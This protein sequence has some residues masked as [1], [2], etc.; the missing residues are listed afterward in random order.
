[1]RP[2]LRT[3]ERINNRPVQIRDPLSR[4]K[5]F[6]TPKR[7][8]RTFRI[9]RK[10]IAMWC[11]KLRR[12]ILRAHKRAKATSEAARIKRTNQ[13]ANN[14]RDSRF[15]D[16]AKATK[17]LF[18]LSRPSTAMRTTTLRTTSMM[19]TMSLVEVLTQTMIMSQQSRR[20]SQLTRMSHRSNA[21]RKS[22]MFR[23]HQMAFS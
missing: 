22:T 20:T 10:L 14:T 11:N 1:M 9:M 21:D 7:G 4:E 17:L 12:T 2:T 23:I 3:M 6:K 16:L 15:L 19:A 18:T 13:T 5:I 8:S